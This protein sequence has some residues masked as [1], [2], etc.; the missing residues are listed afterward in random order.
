MC[1]VFK[2]IL[3]LKFLFNVFLSVKHFV[4]FSLF[5]AL[6]YLNLIYYDTDYW[7]EIYLEAFSLWNDEEDQTE[8]EKPSGLL[9]W[10]YVVWSR[11]LARY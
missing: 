2:F 7:S 4:P 9:Y 5:S 3:F 11:G 10:A 1:S 6:K 8:W